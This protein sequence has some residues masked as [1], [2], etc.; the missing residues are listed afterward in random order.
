MDRQGIICATAA[1]FSDHRIGQTKTVNVYRLITEN[2]LEQKI[3]S[4]KQ[5]KSEIVDALINDTG[6]S[7]LS[8]SKDDLVDLFSPIEKEE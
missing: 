3:M 1:R 4:L 7:T 6:L 8:L 5:R 2:S